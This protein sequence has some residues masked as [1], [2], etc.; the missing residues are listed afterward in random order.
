[1]I[2]AKAMRQKHHPDWDPSAP[3]YRSSPKC[4]VFCYTEHYGSWGCSLRRDH[5]GVH[6]G[7]GNDQVNGEEPVFWWEEQDNHGIEGYPP[8]L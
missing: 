7:W 3:P 6:I 8:W 2:L 1:M 4:F 5:G